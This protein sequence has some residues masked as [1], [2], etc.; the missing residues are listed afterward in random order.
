MEYRRLYVFAAAIGTYLVTGCVNQQP[1]QTFEGQYPHAKCR[2]EATVATA[3]MG[4]VGCFEK[5]IAK[6][7][8]FE[9]IYKQCAALKR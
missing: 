6:I 7:E 1:R 5:N 8:A 3:N 2:Y 4:C 9:D